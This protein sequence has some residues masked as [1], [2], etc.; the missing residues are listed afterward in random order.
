MHIILV[1]L[2]LKLIATYCHRHLVVH[3][4]L[5]FRALYLAD[6][7]LAHFDHLLL[8]DTLAHSNYMFDVVVLLQVV[9]LRNIFCKIINY[10]DSDTDE[11]H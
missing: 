10:L 3:N 7:L 2:S 6:T 4:K 8:A 9:D 11:H 5:L 1:K